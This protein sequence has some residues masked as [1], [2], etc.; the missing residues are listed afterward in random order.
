MTFTFAGSYPPRGNKLDFTVTAGN[1]TCERPVQAG[2]PALHYVHADHLNTPR[3]ITNEAQQ[4]VW[5]WEHQEPF[6]RSPPEEN[7]NGLG[8]FEFNLRFPGQYRDAETGL[9]YN[10]QRDYDPQTGRYVQSDPIGLGAGPN[11]YAY[12]GG[13]PLSHTDPEGLLLSV[14]HA[15]MRRNVHGS[16]V[17]H[18]GVAGVDDR[19]L[20]VLAADYVSQKRFRDALPIY[21]QLS[22]KGY[23]ACQIFVG[24][25]LFEGVGVDKNRAKALEHFQ[26]AAEQGEAAGLFYLGRALTAE[27]AHEEALTWYRLAAERRYMPALFRLGISYLDGLGTAPDEAL[28]L[29]Y[30]RDAAKAGHVLAEGQ[31]AKRYLSGAL[32]LR[33]IP[34]GLLLLVQTCLDAWRFASRRDEFA[35][36]LIG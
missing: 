17:G 25:M 33:M 23:A 27:G 13:N 28:G 2:P 20:H 16:G 6:G 21:E 36:E 15:S 12:V 26:R 34:A 1:V 30:L 14:V 22:E 29:S 31:L 24:W 19:E 18:N 11:T 32:G 10:Y 5:R 8:T 4:L 35:E 3:A 9:F 7:P